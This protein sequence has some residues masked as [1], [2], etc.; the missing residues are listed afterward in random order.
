M[1]SINDSIKGG[2]DRH[3]FVKDGVPY[4]RVWKGDVWKG[5]LN[6]LV[7]N[8]YKWHIWNLYVIDGIG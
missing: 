5:N 8:D 3:L 1:F 2:D 7:I 6:G 4:H